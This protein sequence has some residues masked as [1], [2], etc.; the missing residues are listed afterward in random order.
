MI[1]V[2]VDIDKVWKLFDIFDGIE[3]YAKLCKTKRFQEFL[4]SKVIDTLNDV[5]NKNI[6]S[7]HTT[8]QEEVEL[9]LNSNHIVDTTDGFILYNDATIPADK[10]NL[11]PF[12]TSGYP[13]GQFSIALAFEYGVGIMGQGSYNNG[14]FTPWEY[15]NTDTSRRRT[16]KYAPYWLLPKNVYGLSGILTQGYSGVQ[17]YGDVA[18]MVNRSIHRW[19]CEFMEKEAK[20]WKI[21]MM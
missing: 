9:Y 16:K 12:D 19:T 10:Y 18:R 20:L 8:N 4:K 1:E 7:L 13:S 11:L 3:N 14:Y 15:N 21:N 6:D 5:I 2:N 17:I